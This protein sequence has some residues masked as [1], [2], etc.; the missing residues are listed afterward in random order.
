MLL[1]ELLIKIGVD[2]DAE[3][4]KAFEQSLS[5]LGVSAQTAVG[6]IEKAFD[7]IEPD[8]S[9]IEQTISEALTDGLKASDANVESITALIEERLSAVGT[10]FEGLGLDAQTVGET[11][12]EILAETTE[13]VD[14]LSESEQKATETTQVHTQATEDET[15]T[16]TENAKAVEE[17]TEALEK[18]QKG[19]LGLLG[20]LSLAVFGLQDA[21]DEFHAF[22]AGFDSF[23]EKLG[24]FGLAFAAAGGAITAF[25][26]DQLTALDEV[27]Q[28]GNVTGE[29][30]DYIHRLGQVAELSGSSVQAAQSSILGLSK[31][32]GEAAN[33]T[34]KGAKAFEQYGLS[35]KDAE[36]NIKQT[37]VVLEELRQKMRGMESSEQIAMLAKLGVDGSMIQLLT[38]DLDEFNEQMAEM[39][40]MT[41]GVG[42]EENTTTAAAFKDALTELG[43]MLKSLGETIALRIAPAITELIGKF[44]AWFIENSALIASIGNAI[45]FV[46]GLI[47]DAANAFIT[48]LDRLVS[49]TIGWKNAIYLVGAALAWMGRSLLFNPLT[50]WIAGIAAVLLLI[51]DLIVYMEGGES[52][53]GDY[54]KP[55]ADGLIL[56]GDWLKRVK[57]WVADFVKGWQK[58]TASMQPLINIVRIIGGVFSHLFG[59]IGRIFGALFG[60]SEQTD[61]F[62]R[63]AESIGQIVG[64]VFNDIATAIEVVVGIISVVATTLASSFEIAINVV[65][66]Y[67]QMLYAVWEAIVN[68]FTSGDWLGAFSAMFKK[69]GSIVSDTWHNIKVAAIEFL[70]GLISLVNKFGADIDPIEIPV[71]QVV[72]TVN[73]MDSS[74]IAGTMKSVQSGVNAA[75]IARTGATNNT[76]DNS[77]TN[78]NNRYQVTQHINVQNNAQAQL[79]ADQTAKTIRNTGSSFVQ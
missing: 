58:S 21:R 13:S 19:L 71:K 29:S 3:E 18:N 8:L 75:S 44:K 1:D 16:V 78:S 63:S 73:A 69:M 49:H 61:E 2:I 66:A 74:V 62:G 14:Q 72:S 43:I 76:T 52:F 6:E 50:L 23:G 4:L 51:E 55:I 65:I 42:T 33:G 54:W 36:G 31:V 67:F 47:F 34:G 79:V 22:T 7:Q 41:L 60:A 32:I 37:S 59:I 11:I 77:Q 17:N 35:A 20:E 38:A 64:D 15:K 9:A 56:V 57:T 10:S 45:G 27:R 68:G 40:L 25:V 24:A 28:L 39:Q 5:E 53:F 12:S 48:T 26:D 46:L 70:N 30:T